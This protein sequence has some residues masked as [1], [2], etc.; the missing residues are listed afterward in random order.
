[1]A[2]SV[3]L[4]PVG[5]L[6]ITKGNIQRKAWRQNEQLSIDR[7]QEVADHSKYR[8]SEAERKEESS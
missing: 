1:M 3:M 2:S 7:S 6:Q 4:L 8:Q 5:V